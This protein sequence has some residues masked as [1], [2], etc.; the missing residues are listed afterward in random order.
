VS[1]QA[2]A[3]GSAERGLDRRAVFALL[4]TAVA[5][6]ALE[7]LW[8][9]FRI[10]ARLQDLPY[11]HG[12]APSLAAG[13]QW[14]AATTTA[15]LVIPT[16][17]VLLFHRQG[18]ASAGWR[19]SGF[20]RHV[21]VYL[22]LYLVMVPAILFAAGREDFLQVYPFVS[23]AT[24]DPRAFLVWELAY[25][26]QFFALEAFFR[27]YLLFTLER[28]MGRLAIFV[29]VVP[30]CMIHYHKPMLEALGAVVAGVFL[31]YLAL[32]YRSWYGGAVLHS[33]VAVTM[34]SLAAQRAGLF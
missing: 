24:R 32:R 1:N 14:A 15:F 21:W 8:L 19:W 2:D 29:M 13:V 10:E 5:L 20:L 34:D 12:P 28:V 30:Y 3:E 11:G 27:G 26:T 18:L 9:P 31:G 4:Y 6:T 22:T 33:L 16:A 23:E 17:V 7:Y 25:V